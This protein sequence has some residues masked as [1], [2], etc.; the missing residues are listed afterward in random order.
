[1][2]HGDS[3]L[4]HVSASFCCF[5]YFRSLANPL[6]Q[7]HERRSDWTKEGEA[8]SNKRPTTVCRPAQLVNVIHPRAFEGW[9]F[10]RIQEVLKESLEMRNSNQTE[11]VRYVR[12]ELIASSLCFLNHRLN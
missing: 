8:R 1:M 2:N 3:L 11:R 9:Q 10:R 7:S 4:S 5:D 6:L 12:T